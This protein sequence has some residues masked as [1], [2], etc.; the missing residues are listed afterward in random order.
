MTGATSIEKYIK[1][2]L[3]QSI[4]LFELA[5][6]GNKKSHSGSRKSP[7]SK[8]V[9][10]KSKVNSFEIKIF[11]NFGRVKVIE[12]VAKGSINEIKEMLYQ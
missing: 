8:Q 7:K 12:E 10:E 3:S 1:I 9:A 11:E 4:Y 2:C 6:L 5:I